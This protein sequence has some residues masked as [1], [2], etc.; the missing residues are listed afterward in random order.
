[1]LNKT[2]RFYNGVEIPVIGLGTWQTPNK[3]AA[4]VVEEGIEVGYIH[5]DTAAAYQNEQG[6]GEGLKLSGVDRSKIF[7]TSKY[8]E[9]WNIAF[10]RSNGYY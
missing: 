8:M 5:I 1:M 4:R 6:V 10:I 7:I 2:V 3:I 9:M